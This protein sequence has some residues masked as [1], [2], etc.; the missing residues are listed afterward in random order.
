MKKGDGM[1][2]CWKKEENR[3]VETWWLVNGVAWRGEVSE[4]V[5]R[6]MEK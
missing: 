6:K 3:D 1:M 5:R 2:A 4:V